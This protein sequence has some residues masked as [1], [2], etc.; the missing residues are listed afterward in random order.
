MGIRPTAEF[1]SLL[2]KNPGNNSLKLQDIKKS[3]SLNRCK[4]DFG[5]SNTASYTDLR[6]MDKTN[7]RFKKNPT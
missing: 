1:N 5:N 3:L 6:K 7:C 2:R 4:S